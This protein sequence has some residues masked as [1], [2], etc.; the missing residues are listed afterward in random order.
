MTVIS[1]REFRDNQKRYFDLID[2][3]G[4]IIIQRGKNKSYR[5]I[6]VLE[7]ETLM[8]EADFY[9]KIDKSIQQAKEGKVTRFENL[10]AFKEFLGL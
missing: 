5:L 9:A 6:P 8:T 4:Q 7:K 1:S 2:S 3:D 10:D